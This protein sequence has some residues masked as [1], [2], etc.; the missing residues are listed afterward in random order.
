MQASKW[1]LT[2]HSVVYD[3]A[4]PSPARSVRFKAG[5]QL[6][7]A[8]LKEEEFSLLNEILFRCLQIPN[9][10]SYS[11][12]FPRSSISPVAFRTSPLG[13]FCCCSRLS[14]SGAKVAVLLLQQML[15]LFSS[16]C[17][18]HASCLDHLWAPSG[19]FSLLCLGLRLSLSSLLLAAAAL[20]PSRVILVSAASPS[21]LNTRL[22][23]PRHQS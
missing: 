7:N 9:W 11:W 1:T 18:W 15:H 2:L 22:T 23:V 21:V 5:S 16:L 3:K 19:P 17:W 4:L 13:G 10:S 6:V 14:V 20:P 12:L 8:A